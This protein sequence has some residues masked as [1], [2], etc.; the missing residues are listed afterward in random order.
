VPAIQPVPE[1]AKVNALI[2]HR[3]AVAAGLAAVLAAALATDESAPSAPAV[4]RAT[5]AA[6]LPVRMGRRVLIAISSQ[7]T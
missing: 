2:L 7:A 5:A 1:E 3:D 4:V 6:R